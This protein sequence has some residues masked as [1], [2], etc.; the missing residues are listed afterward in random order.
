[1][2]KKKRHEN[3]KKQK[4]IVSIRGE[5]VVIVVVVATIV[6]VVVGVEVVAGDDV[7]DV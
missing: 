2:W 7:A 5:P 1:M 6:V 4:I 3:V